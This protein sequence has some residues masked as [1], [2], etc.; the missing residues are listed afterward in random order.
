MDHREI[1]RE[2]L[3]HRL[4]WLVTIRWVAILGVFTGAH[5]ARELSALSF[6]LLPAY[7]ILGIASLAN[8]AY[9]TRLRRPREDLGRLALVQIVIDQLLLAA[10]IYFSGD[11]DSPF[12]YFFIFHVAISGIIL[13]WRQAYALAAMA[14]LLPAGIVSLR[15]AGVLPHFEIFRHKPIVADSTVALFYGMSFLGT[16]ALTAYFVTYLSRQLHARNNEVLKLYK[17]SERLRSSLRLQD[18]LATLEQE[19]GALVDASTSVYLPLDRGRRTLLLRQG[20]QEITVPLI[21]RNSFTEATLRGVP[22]VL[23]RRYCTSDY[24]RTACE[25][26]NAAHCMILPVMAA[27]PQPCYEYFQCRDQECDA[28][29]REDRRCWQHAR[30]HCRGAVFGNFSDKM[31]VCSACELFT[32]VGVFSLSVPAH[33]RQLFDVDMGSAMRLLDTAGLAV[34]NALLHE[35]AIRLAKIDGLTGLRNHRDFKEALQ[36][37]LV[38]VSR[39]RRGLSL[40]MIDVDHF[41]H[42]NDTNGHPQGDVLLKKLAELLRDN[43]KESDIVARYGGEEFAVLLLETEEKDQALLVAERLRGMV[44]WCKFPNEAMQPNGRIT[45]SVGVSCYPEDGATLDTLIQAADEALYRAKR[46][47]RN[48]VVAASVT[49]D[50]LLSPPANELPA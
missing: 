5:I 4:Q 6:S 18:V 41:K 24:E 38:R 46:G 50:Q 47:G 1:D 23:D 43:F 33:R 31:A 40:L 13:P 42:Y 30:T 37:E 3:L 34:A 17:L 15:H 26:Q 49:T 11:W 44:D 25:L 9:R 10:A 48:R 36:A 35:R 7:V 27:A 28:Y 45:I 14:F 32:P 29:G 16:I 19:L 22:L 8:L 12:L 21:D 2:V 39:Y 20:G